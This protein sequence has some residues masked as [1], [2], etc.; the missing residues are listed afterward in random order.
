VNDSK[1]TLN[2]PRKNDDWAD[3]TGNTATLLPGWDNVPI[4]ELRWKKLT[5]Y[6]EWRLPPESRRK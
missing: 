4:S 3:E 2:Q 6:Q 1:T 5:D